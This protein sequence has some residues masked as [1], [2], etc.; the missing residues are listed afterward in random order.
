MK[1]AKK[2]FSKGA[3]LLV[4]AI[5][6]AAAFV[7]VVSMPGSFASAADEADVNFTVPS[8]VTPGD[9]FDLHI[10]IHTSMTGWGMEINTAN[11]FTYDR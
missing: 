7:G 5:V 10:V 1:T 6:F 3:L 4:I 8:N 2:I 11:S 9:T